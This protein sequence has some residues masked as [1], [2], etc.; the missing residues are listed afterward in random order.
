[1]CVICDLISFLY[2]SFLWS[3]NVL[4]NVGDKFTDKVDTPDTLCKFDIQFI[5]LIVEFFHIT[6]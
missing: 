1:M 6:M 4:N 2:L 5:Y 3:H